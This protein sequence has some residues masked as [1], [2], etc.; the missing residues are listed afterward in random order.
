[1]IDKNKYE[2]MNP[3]EFTQKDLMLHLLHV[4]QHT[5]TR[6]DLKDDIFKVETSLNQKFESLESSIDKRFAQVDKKFGQVDRRFEQVD[7]R[8]EQIDRRFEQID[9]RFDK[10]DNEIKK[11]QTLEIKIAES[12][13]ET[14]KWIVTM[15][16]A[17]IV[18]MAGLGFAAFKIF[19]SN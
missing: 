8:F 17:N 6:E 15:F 12:K 10:V 18:A 9:R 1:M 13:N 4:S 19:G 5:V 14:V 16:F 2:N 11:L 3:N 7:K